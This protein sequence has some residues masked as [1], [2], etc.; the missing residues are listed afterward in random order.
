MKPSRHPVVL[1]HGLWDTEKVFTKLRTHLQTQGWDVHSFNM[2]PANGSAPLDVLAE[3]LLHFVNSTFSPDQTLD[4]VGFSMGGIVSRYYLQRLG[5][6]DRVG[7]FVSISSPHKGTLTA[8]GSRHQG[9][10]QMRPTH[11]FIK[12]LNQD[13]HQLEQVQFTSLWTP[14]DIM[15]LPS[16]SSVLSVGR[17]ERLSVSLHKNMISD[18][19]SLRAITQAL[20]EPLAQQH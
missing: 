8:Y 5:G 7:R 20:A 10:K 17:T 11:S 13:L 4:L 15:I 1:V 2:L 16:N 14:Y 18:H 19:R 9:C 12:D 3:Q 6:I